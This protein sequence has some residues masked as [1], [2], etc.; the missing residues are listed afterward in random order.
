MIFASCANAIRSFPVS[1]PDGIRIGNE[2]H[3]P[4]IR[5][6]CALCYSGGMAEHY[7]IEQAMGMLGMSRNRVARWMKKL[8]ITPQDHPHEGRVKLLSED[9]IQHIR[10]ASEAASALIVP[11]ASNHPPLALPPPDFAHSAPQRAR[12]DPNPGRAR[13]DKPPLPDGW[14]SFEDAWK[15]TGIAGN[16]QKSQVDKTK[17]ATPGPFLR[18]RAT[19]EWA[20]SPEQQERFIA[21]F[22]DGLHS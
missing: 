1:H 15:L 19:I 18:N 5:I 17:W 9:D 4:A 3:P 22:G 2:C 20:L 11:K 21:A 13:S 16:W 8:N 14:I 10:D 7:S 6:S 12:R